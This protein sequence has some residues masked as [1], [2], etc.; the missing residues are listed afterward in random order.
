MV[1]HVKKNSKYYTWEIHLDFL[2]IDDYAQIDVQNIICQ[3][4]NK[5]IM[6]QG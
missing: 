4:G 1:Y 5:H 6:A 2:D 3:K